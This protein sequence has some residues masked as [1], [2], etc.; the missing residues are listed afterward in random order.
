M[1]V[2][3]GARLRFR[4]EIELQVSPQEYT[5]EVTLSSLRRSDFERRASFPHVDLYARI[6]QLCVVT[7]AGAFTVALRPVGTRPI[8]ILHHGAANLPGTCAV[9]VVPGGGA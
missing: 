2:A 3:R 9:Q 1:R 4:H 7:R 5:Y 6:E 8:Q